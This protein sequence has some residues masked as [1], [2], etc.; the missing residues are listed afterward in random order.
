MINTCEKQ[1]HCKYV[2]SEIM[3][4]TCSNN[5]GKYDNY[6]ED[7]DAEEKIDLSNISSCDDKSC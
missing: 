4:K 7:Y 2:D 3:C 1:I 5:G 6:E